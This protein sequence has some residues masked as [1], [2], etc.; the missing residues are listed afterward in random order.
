MLVVFPLLTW[1]APVSKFDGLAFGR[2]GFAVPLTKS[3]A[4][5]WSAPP[6]AASLIPDGLIHSDLIHSDLKLYLG[7]FFSSPVS[8]SF[9]TMKGNP[10]DRPSHVPLLGEGD[11]DSSGSPTTT[12]IFLMIVCGAMLKYFASPG[13]YDVVSD[14]CSTLLAIDN[15]GRSDVCQ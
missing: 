11:A 8:A 10:G 4:F 13:F 2:N 3:S 9:T 15:E 7:D 6:E 12:S 1:A 5:L 14:V